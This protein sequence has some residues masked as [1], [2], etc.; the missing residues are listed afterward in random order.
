MES[1]SDDKAKIDEL[2]AVHDATKTALDIISELLSG[3]KE[4]NASTA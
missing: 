1:A 3:K 4:K 2:K